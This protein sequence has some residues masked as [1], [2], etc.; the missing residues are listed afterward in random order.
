MAAPG[1]TPRCQSRP[2]YRTEPLH[3]RSCWQRRTLQTSS[4]ASD[5]GPVAAWCPLAP[6]REAPTDI[7]ELSIK[8]GQT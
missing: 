5:I 7:R 6:S 2:R 4:R 8:S 1:S 3:H